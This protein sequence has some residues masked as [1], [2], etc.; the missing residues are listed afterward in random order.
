VWVR[1]EFESYDREA[2]VVHVR[3]SVG[4]FSAVWKGRDE[5]L[6]GGGAYVEFTT[7]PTAV[8]GIDVIEASADEPDSI[9]QDEDGWT[10][11]GTILGR[12]PDQARYERTGRIIPDHDLRDGICY[13]QV[14]DADTIMMDTDRLDPTAAGRR[15]RVRQTEVQ[16][17]P[18]D[19]FGY[20]VSG[21]EWSV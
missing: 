11:I 3:S 7:G 12:G 16:L 14:N 5:P 8:W 1:V 2:H 21:T 17:F 18:F 20:T 4:S 19:T 9:F 6:P 15:F 13:L 10:F